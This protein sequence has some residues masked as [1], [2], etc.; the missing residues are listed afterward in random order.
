M[1]VKFNDKF[2]IRNYQS[3]DYPGI[4]HLWKLTDLGKPERGDDERTIEGSISL[5]G[6]LLV[7]VENETGLI[8]GTSWMTFDGRRIHLHH[9]GILPEYQGKSLSRPLL[10]A[11]L[12]F[13][14]KKGYQVKLEVHKNNYKAI[15]IYKN[16]GFKYLGDYDVYIIRDLNSIQDEP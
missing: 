13:V 10:K 7:M 5:G 3:G 16:A 9:F 2:T 1:A 8:C 6:C 11:S 14:R 4:M 15:N 12:D